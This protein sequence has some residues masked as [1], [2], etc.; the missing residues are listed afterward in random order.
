[1]KQNREAVTRGRNDGDF[2]ISRGRMGVLANLYSQR[3]KMA[4]SRTEAK[5][6]KIS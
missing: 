3:A 6:R 2:Q 4:R 5:I 1:M